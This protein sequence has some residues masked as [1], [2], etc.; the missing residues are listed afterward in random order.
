VGTKGVVVVVVVGGVATVVVVV[1]AA[2][3]V[4]FDGMVVG[5]ARE[6]AAGRWRD[7]GCRRLLLSFAG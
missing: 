2:A 4:V 7:C 1:A 6:G 5:Y 3:A